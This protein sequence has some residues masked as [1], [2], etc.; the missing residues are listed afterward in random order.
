MLSDD[1]HMDRKVSGSDDLLPK[2][3]IKYDGDQRLN[4]PMALLGCYNNLTSIENT[5]SLIQGEGFMEIDF[6]YL[7]GLWVL[8]DFNSI[9]TRHIFFDHVCIN[10]W[11]S[12][13]KPW[14]DDLFVKERIV[15]LEIEGVSMLAWCNSTY[16][17]IVSKH[18]KLFCLENQHEHNR[19]SM[20]VLMLSSHIYLVF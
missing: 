3:S 9:E 18:S 19:Y 17:K 7:G 4:Y 16:K 2:T 13:F 1:N 8:L 15:R 5:R 20:R 10:T 11:F 12:V 6:F 14:K